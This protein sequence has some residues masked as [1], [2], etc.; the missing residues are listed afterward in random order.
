MPPKKRQKIAPEEKRITGIL[1]ESKVSIFMKKAADKEKEHC[2][3]RWDIFIAGV[4]SHHSF[5]P[6]IVIK[7]YRAK[8]YGSFKEVATARLCKNSNRSSSSKKEKQPPRLPTLLNKIIPKEFKKKLKIKSFSDRKDKEK[9]MFALLKK[10]EIDS[11]L[12]QQMV[13]AVVDTIKN[14]YSAQGYSIQDMAPPEQKQTDPAPNNETTNDVATILAQLDEP[15]SSQGLHS[16]DID[17]PEFEDGDDNDTEE[18][19]SLDD[20]DVPTSSNNSGEEKPHS[21]DQV[22]LQYKK[23]LDDW[24]FNLTTLTL[25]LPYLPPA[26]SFN[27][28]YAIQIIKHLNEGF[29][30]IVNLK[31]VGKVGEK[32][33][34]SM[35]W[36]VPFH[37]NEHWK[38]YANILNPIFNTYS[39][40][41]YNFFRAAPQPAASVTDTPSIITVPRL[42]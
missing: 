4:K 40:N 1:E 35:L 41:R 38:N 6:A 36:L 33:T 8:A 32:D 30:N 42:E 13:N 12:R 20:S 25:L 37:E 3:W 2:K 23:Q 19:T 18:E 24:N 15:T 27:H 28:C 31:N 17:I 26:D 14:V 39:T 29:N 34:P 21:V 11:D 7:K 16:T 22:L 10:D 5:R 9:G